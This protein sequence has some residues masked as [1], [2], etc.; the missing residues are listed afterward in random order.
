MDN[1]TRFV[2]LNGGKHTLALIESLDIIA[3]NTGEVVKSLKNL[4]KNSLASSLEKS[5]H[6]EKQEKLQADAEELECVRMYLDSI[7]A[8]LWGEDDHGNTVKLT[9]VGRVMNAIRAVKEGR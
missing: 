2:T 6:D 1:G 4:E 8:P 5:V 7:D 3:K 9:T